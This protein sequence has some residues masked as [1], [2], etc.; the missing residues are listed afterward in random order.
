MALEILNRVSDIQ[1]VEAR[2]TIR[3]MDEEASETLREL[4][5][6]ELEGTYVVYNGCR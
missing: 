1:S 2:N 6:K 5:G 3:L 4:I